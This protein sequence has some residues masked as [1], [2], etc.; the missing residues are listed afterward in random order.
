MLRL[1]G[2][3]KPQNIEDYRALARRRL[4]SMAWAYIDGGSE[5]QLTL[6]ANRDAFARYSLRSHVLS[7][8]KPTDIGVDLFGTRLDLP[9][10]LAPTG[11]S[12]L[13]HWTGELA[14]ARAAEKAGTRAILSTA[15]SYSPEEIAQGTEQDHWYQLYPWVNPATGDRE[16]VSSL[17]RRAERSGFAALAITV[18]VPV[19][20]NREGE[21]RVGMGLRP[22]V[23]PGRLASALIRPKWTTNFLLHRRVGARALVDGGGT[24]SAVRS[25]RVQHYHMRPELNW[26]DLAWVRD[27]WQKPMLIKGVLDPDDAQRAVD[28]G[29]DGV[30]VSNHGGRQL[31][32]APASLDALPAIAERLQGRVPIILDS[33]VR[34]GVDVIKALS[35]GATA[36]AIGR[37]YLYG[38]AVGGERGVRDVLEILRAEV[39]RALTLMGRPGLSSLSRDSLIDSPGLR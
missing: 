11:F 20:G 5:D 37:P 9:I 26:D 18:D 15:A 33:G 32:G 27:N 16:L 13:A 7:G 36:V 35:L 2:D 6:R 31:D 24:G 14:A 19:V 39:L 8:H 30:I 1:T 3:R 22:V 29:L 34:R 12:A 38:L 4:P 21:R 10:L 25:A 28:L 17:L 23:T